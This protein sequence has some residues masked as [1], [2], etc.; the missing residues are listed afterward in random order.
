MKY[1]KPE[2]VLIGPATETVLNMSK[3]NGLVDIVDPKNPFPS[4]AAYESDE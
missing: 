2:L 4:V 3:P 1:E